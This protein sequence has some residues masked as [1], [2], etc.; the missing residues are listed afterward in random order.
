MGEIYAGTSGWGYSSWRPGFYPAKL[1]PGRFLQHYAGRLNS[2]EVNYTFG[3]RVSK[4]LLQRWAAAVPEQFRFAVKAH[5][6]ITHSKRLRD[7]GAATAEFLAS[8]EP[9][10][11]VGKLGPVLFQLPG[12]FKCDV[13]RLREFLAGLPTGVRA[14]FEFRH[15]SW[16]S[17]RVYAALRDGGAS[18]CMAE[19]EKLE[20]PEV[21]TADFCYLRL[22]KK[23]YS[24]KTVAERLR[25]LAGSGDVFVYFKHEETPTGPSRAEALLR[26][27]RKK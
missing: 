16:F 17:E 12:N 2:V 8:L 21:V 13:G 27:V 3:R 7:A 15:E 23:K 5:R 10:R 26:L 24:R 11:L 9:L 20:T 22:R 6:R 19:D 25:R 1:G 4:Q 18:L 14:A